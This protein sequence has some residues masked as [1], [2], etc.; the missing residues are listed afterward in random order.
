MRHI[1]GALYA[2]ERHAMARLQKRFQSKQ[3]AL[4][5]VANGG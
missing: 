3:E 1:C 5:D 4:R 2:T